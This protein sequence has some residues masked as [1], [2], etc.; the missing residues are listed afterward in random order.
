MSGDRLAVAVADL[1][2]A[3]LEQPRTGTEANRN[4]PPALLDVAEAARALPACGHRCDP[5]EL[6]AIESTDA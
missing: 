1:I 4:G 5:G 3:F 6:L 2:D